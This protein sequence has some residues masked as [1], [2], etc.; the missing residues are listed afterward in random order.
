MRHLPSIRA[1]LAMLCPLVNT[2]RMLLSAIP[3]V[4]LVGVSVMSAPAVALSHEEWLMAL[5]R[6]VDWPTPPADNTLAICQPFDAPLLVLPNSQVRGLTMRV[7]RVSTPQQVNRCHVFSALS[8]KEA[9]WESWLAA[10]KSQPILV[11]GS[12][13]RFC[14]FGGAVC[15]VKDEETKV[16]KYQVN[17]DSLSRSGLRVRSRVDSCAAHSSPHSQERC[18]FPRRSAA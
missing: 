17:L 8:M 9:E 4:G 11:V 14:E 10:L 1:Q 7:V 16:E 12:G 15:L 13:A 2:A 18:R 3:I 5:V 6:F